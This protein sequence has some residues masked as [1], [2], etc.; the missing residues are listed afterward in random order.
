MARRAAA[1]VL[2]V[3]VCLLAPLAVVG[4]WGRDRFLDSDGW[5]ELAAGITEDESSRDAVAAE[6]TD[7]VLDGL[8]LGDRIQRRAEPVVRAAT[9]AALQSDAFADVWIEANRAVHESL[10]RTLEADHGSEVR[11]DLRPAVALVLDA[12]EEPLAPVAQMP[13]D[14][15]EF[16]EAPSPEEAEAAIEAGLGRPLAEDRATV[17]VIRD[18]RI[19]TARSVY[20]GVDRGAFLLA[21]AT[22]LLA[23]LAVAIGRDRWKTAAAIGL[24]SAVT[25][26]IAWVATLGT[27][28]TVGGFF[29]EGV[30]RSVAEAAAR[31]AAEDLGGRYVTAA[32]VL[33]I[34]GVACAVVGAVRARTP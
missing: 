15:P 34:A 1:G 5:A 17:V 18:D 23:A 4:L 10:V 12:V 20:R 29:G 3:L 33:G 25:M 30:G 32:I 2:V 16:D 19:A 28:N 7:V 27:G 22:V 14:V 26:M 9:D 11:L 13:G 6:I 8:D 31:V 21:L 24:G